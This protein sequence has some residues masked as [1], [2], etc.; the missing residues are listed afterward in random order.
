MERGEGAQKLPLCAPAAFLSATACTVPAVRAEQPQRPAGRGRPALPSSLG[1]HG[2]CL[3]LLTC[4]LATSC[5]PACPALQANPL[6]ESGD[7]DAFEVLEGLT[8]LTFLSLRA[9]QLR[10]L[11][12][13][14]A[15]L[16]ALRALDC[17]FQQ[18][19]AGGG[20]AFLPLGSLRGLERLDVACN[21]LQRLPAQLSALSSLQELT[22]HRNRC[23]QRAQH[24]WR[25]CG[26]KLA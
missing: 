5:H 24:A 18:L 14:L 15:A 16:R 10:C 26:G 11:P 21:G 12:A 20:D 22:L 2:T 6:G 4:S 13:A 23:A 9:C 1:P 7:E 17:G 8:A 25:D 19:G 3:H